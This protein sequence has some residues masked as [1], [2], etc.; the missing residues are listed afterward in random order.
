MKNSR[1]ILF[2]AILIALVAVAGVGGCKKEAMASC[3]DG[4][5]NQ[6]E[7]GVDCGGS[8]SACVSQLCDGAGSNSYFPLAIGNTWR[9]NQGGTDS[10]I[11]QSGSI[12]IDHY[13]YSPNYYFDTL[14]IAGNG[15]VYRKSEG[16]NEILL[17]PAILYAG[18][19]WAGSQYPGWTDSNT[20]VDINASVN[21]GFC[22]YT[23]CAKIERIYH[24]PSSP[25]ATIYT[26]IKKG[27]GLVYIARFV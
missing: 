20:V 17:V 21:T 14:R 5:K 3:T 1:T 23:N 15:D 26:Y 9:Y 19:K 22:T 12:Y 11:E 18:L 8:C 6:N 4:I 13:F 2:S 16:Q 25:T 24:Y 27:I 10:V 7:T